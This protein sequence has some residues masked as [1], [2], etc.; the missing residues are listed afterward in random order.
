MTVRWLA[1]SRASRQPLYKRQ[2]SIASILP[3]FHPRSSH[4]DSGILQFLKDPFASLQE[5]VTCGRKLDMPSGSHEEL[6]P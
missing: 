2:T 4:L 6:G 5:R 1:R 3:P